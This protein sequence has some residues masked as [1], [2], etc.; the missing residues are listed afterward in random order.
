MRW[1]MNILDE[2]VQANL[3]YMLMTATVLTY[4]MK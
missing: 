4:F 1:K 2:T 3:K